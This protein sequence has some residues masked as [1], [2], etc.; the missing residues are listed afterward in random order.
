MAYGWTSSELLQSESPLIKAVK[1]FVDIHKL[2]VQKSP[3]RR[4]GGD[5]GN[6]KHS[7]RQHTACSTHCEVSNIVSNETV[8]VQR[9]RGCS[10]SAIESNS[11]SEATVFSGSERSAIAESPADLRVGSEPSAGTPTAHQELTTPAVDEGEPNPNP[12]AKKKN[13]TAQIS[14]S[15]GHRSKRASITNEDEEH[16]PG[17]NPNPMRAA[18]TEAT[19]SSQG[20]QEQPIGTSSAMGELTATPSAL[21]DS[22]HLELQLS[23]EEYVSDHYVSDRR[24]DPI[25]AA[26]SQ[27]PDVPIFRRIRGGPIGGQPAFRRGGGDFMISGRD[28]P[29]S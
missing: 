10:L 17:G 7:K 9:P 4:R 27:G 14:E 25:V 29:Q 2:S 20:E 11:S 1:S 12:N 3:K 13:R 16:T 15:P 18:I 26:S 28:Q 19:D 23:P 21:E 24:Y 22:S 8:E 5:D 6:I